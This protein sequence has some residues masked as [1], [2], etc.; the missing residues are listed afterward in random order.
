MHGGGGTPHM[1]EL[2]AVLLNHPA[3]ILCTHTEEDEEGE[4]HTSTNMNKEV[5]C[6]NQGSWSVLE[7]ARGYTKKSPAK[8]LV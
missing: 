6:I 1:Q 7:K 5:L 4:V 8:C 2:E 3:R